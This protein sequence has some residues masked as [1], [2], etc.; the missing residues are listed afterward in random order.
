MKLSD[1]INAFE[2][3]GCFCRDLSVKKNYKKLFQK[4]YKKNNFFTE[5]NIQ[6]TLCSISNM[7]I[8]SEIENLVA[9]F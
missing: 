1:R 8:K 9:A 6:N 7:L 3:L 4:V 5:E 2:Q